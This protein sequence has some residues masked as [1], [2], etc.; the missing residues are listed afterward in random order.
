M[1]TYQLGVVAL[2]GLGMLPVIT[3]CKYP[4]QQEVA[5]ATKAQETPPI[6]VSVNSSNSDACC[7]K[8]DVEEELKQQ[9]CCG[10]C[11]DDS[12]A[13]KEGD[14]ENCRKEIATR[15][16]ADG[17]SG[18][19]GAC[20]KDK[21]ENCKCEDESSK[22]TTKSHVNSK[23]EDRDIFHY[24]LN[25]HEKITR[26]VTN[27]KNGVQTTTES[28]DPAI[29]AKIREHVDSM[30]GRIKD[31]RR[32]RN[33]DELFVKIFEHADEIDMKVIPTERASKWL[34]PQAIPKSPNSFSNMLWLF[35]DL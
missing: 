1:K 21:A 27:T 10:K 23:R 9:A 3:G 25:H 33:W 7:G 4:G 11:A 15:D 35:P 8:C 2:C 20:A 29:A 28:D 31:A 12:V 22:K 17:C 14:C 5:A 26:T 18:D 6:G 24:L 19:C 30:H 34:R 16:K 32:L 13:K